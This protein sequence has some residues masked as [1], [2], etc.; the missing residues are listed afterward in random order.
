MRSLLRQRD[1]IINALRTA[2][3]MLAEEKMKVSVG[4]LF[5]NHSVTEYL[6]TQR[7]MSKKALLWVTIPLLLPILFQPVAT[8]R[9]TPGMN[10]ESEQ[11]RI[12]LPLVE[13][14]P[15]PLK[16]GVHVS[17]WEWNE[18]ATEHVQLAAETGADV[19]R[20]PISWFLLQEHG[21]G[22]FSSWYIGV[23]RDLLSVAEQENLTVIFMMADPPAWAVDTT[24]PGCEQGRAHW[25]AP[26][27]P[28]DYANAI[29]YL[30][31][32]LGTPEH[33]NVLTYFEVWNEPNYRA[34]GTSALTVEEYVTLLAA[35]YRTI[36]PK[37]PNVQIIG[38]ALAGTDTEYLHEMYSL[39]AEPYF[40]ILSIHPYPYGNILP[41]E[42]CTH[43]AWSY[44]CGVPA[45]RDV[46][47]SVNDTASVWFTEI[48]W[49]SYDGNGG[50]GLTTQQDYAAR[51]LRLIHDQGWD[52]VETVLWYNLV[53]CT[54]RAASDCAPPPEDYHAYYGLHDQSLQAK[55]VVDSFAPYPSLP[56]KEDLGTL[57][58]P[59]DAHEGV[60][61]D[62]DKSGAYL[63][64]IRSGVY[65]PWPQ[66]N[67]DNEQ[68]RSILYIYR[69]REVE[70]KQKPWGLEPDNPDYTLGLWEN[71]GEEREMAEQR[72]INATVGI[73]LQPGEFIRIM[74]I[75][76]QDAYQGN[77][78]EVILHIQRFP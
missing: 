71:P 54:D 53:D 41:P 45:I 7:M 52:F 67:D 16:L 34:V 74:P 68:W 21:K 25:C 33:A 75:D 47:L 56:L 42:D 9:P 55:P 59:G 60:R 3:T 22:H 61:F 29:L 17:I 8:Y 69:N 14:S 70:W 46:M 44:L 39:G 66:A 32:T 6:L 37:I 76:V 26:T 24:E 20:I 23:L 64:R 51:A 40:D 50:V 57:I 72:G 4:L 18:T 5:R 31:E 38:G 10:V 58:V 1:V 35:T 19:V 30:L 63:I 11:H 48:G 12:Y 62:A 49:S 13:R 43:E 28:D 15:L 78:G 27:D 36:K 2:R 73:A 77:R 65:S